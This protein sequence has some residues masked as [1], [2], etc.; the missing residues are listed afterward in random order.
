MI[1][2]AFTILKSL[3]LTSN[4]KVDRQ[5][6]PAPNQSRPEL[7]AVY[8]AARTPIE[9]KLAEIWRKVLD[10]E[11]VGIHDNFFELGGHS[12]LITQLLALV[13]S[14]FEVDLP[15]R[16]LFKM[17]TVAGLAETIDTTLETKNSSV[18]T[19]V[20]IFDLNAEAVLDPEINPKAATCNFPVL[21]NAIFLTGATGFLGAFLLKELLQETAADIYC[22]VR[23]SNIELGKKKLQHSLEAY[24]LWNESFTTR[25][26]PVLGDLSRP[27]LGLSGEEFG[28]LASK[29]DTIYHNGALVNFTYPY[30]ALKA[31][32]VFGTQEVLRLASQVKLKP[33]HFISTIGV[34]GSTTSVIAS[35]DR[36]EVKIIKEQDSLPRADEHSSGY[37][38]SKWVAEKLVTIARD[39]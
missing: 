9:E 21:E 4:G 28:S 22:L 34:V 17:P 6:L 30:A 32:N 11:Q 1:P 26:I 31:A 14:A 33:V 36:S 25:I 8:V 37:T 10:I 18:R 2:S 39:R 20:E 38:Q 5:A 23:S 13:R 29:V 27:L 35:V 3:P 16:S 7:E 19:S 15:L 12:L 24:L